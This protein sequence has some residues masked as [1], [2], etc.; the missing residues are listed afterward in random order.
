MKRLRR[1]CVHLCTTRHA[2]GACTTTQPTKLGCMQWTTQKSS[3]PPEP[4][5]FRPVSPPG[6][7]KVMHGKGPYKASRRT[8]PAE[9]TCIHS[10]PHVRYGGFLASPPV[11]LRKSRFFR[12][13]SVPAGLTPGAVPIYALKRALR[14]LRAHRARR[15]DF[16]TFK[17]APPFLRFLAYFFVFVGAG[18]IYRVFP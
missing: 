13:K 5:R 3:P 16:Y 9:P 15:I 7:C 6:P 14:S 12:I 11:V 4:N 17:C 1:F 10:S 8:A 18:A 2:G